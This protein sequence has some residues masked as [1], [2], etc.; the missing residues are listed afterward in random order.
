MYIL[1]KMKYALEHFLKIY[2]VDLSIDYPN[3]FFFEKKPVLKV[4]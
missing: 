3:L 4:I 2:Y 1:K